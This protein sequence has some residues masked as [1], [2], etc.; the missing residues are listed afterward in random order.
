[1]LRLQVEF[2]T[3]GDGS[4]GPGKG[5]WAGTVPTDDFQPYSS[6]YNHVALG[7]TLT[8][9]LP[10]M[11]PVASQ[12]WIRLWNGNWWIAWDGVWF[13]Y[14]PG[15]LFKFSAGFDTGACEALWYGEAYNPGYDTNP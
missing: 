14:Y 12:F 7:L 1:M 11:P 2:M 10:G 15:E 6:T 4:L 8:V 9:S 3:A 13:G 5:V